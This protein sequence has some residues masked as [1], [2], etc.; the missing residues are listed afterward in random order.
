VFIQALGPGADWYLIYIAESKGFES[1]NRSAEQE[2]IALFFGAVPFWATT[3]NE[4]ANAVRMVAK[5][6]NMFSRNKNQLPFLDP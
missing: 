5:H 6:F 1:D 4:K 3:G 2:M